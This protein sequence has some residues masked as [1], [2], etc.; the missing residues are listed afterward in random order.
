VSEVLSSV[1]DRPGNTVRRSAYV[2]AWEP[3]IVPNQ[4]SERITPSV[5]LF[6][7]DK[8]IVGNTPK[9]RQRSSHRVVSRSRTMGPNFVFEYEGHP[10][11]A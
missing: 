4:E 1:R 6:D 8:V 7:G 10:T 5:V 9:S 2:D 11:G 3:I